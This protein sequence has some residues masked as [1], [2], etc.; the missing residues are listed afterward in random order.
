LLGISRAEAY[1][2]IKKLNSELAEKG[3]IVI[4]GRVSRRYLEEQIYSE[5][6]APGWNMKCAMYRTLPTARLEL[7]WRRIP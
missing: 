5:V 7:P 3:Y 2:I 4:S 6:S 1:R